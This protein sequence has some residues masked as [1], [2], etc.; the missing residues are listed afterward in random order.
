MNSYP[1]LFKY[2]GFN[3]SVI[4]QQQ[5]LLNQSLNAAQQKFQYP[6]PNY[7]LQAFNLIFFKINL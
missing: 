7:N 4:D 2:P 3:W 1:S 6:N 5:K